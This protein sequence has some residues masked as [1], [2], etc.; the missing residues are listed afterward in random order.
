[1]RYSFGDYVL[2]TQRQELQRVGEPIKL[3]RKVFQVLAYLL[4]H[5]ERVVPK[6]ELLEHLW[7]DQF[8]GDETLKSCIKTLRK[9][10]GDSRRTARFLHTVHGQGYRFVAAVAVQESL[11]VDEAPPAL[12]LRGSEGATCQAEVPSPALTPSHADL[13]STPW[14]TLEG[15]YKQAT[16]L[17]GA[18]A[19]APTLAAR[20]GP[21]A[22]YHL[23]REVLALAQATVQRYE[24]TLHQVSGE[25]FLALF[26]VPV[27]QEDHARRAV[28]AAL[29]L[30]QRLY[31]PE[32]LRGLLHGVAI[33]LG[34]HSGPVVV[35]SLTYEPQRLYIAAGETLH[36]ATRLQE[37]ATPDSILVSAAT[38]VLVQD[39][40]Q[41]EACETL[42]LDGPSTPVPVYAIHG[43]RRRRAGVPRR[44]PRPLSRFVGRTQELALLQARLEQALGGQGQVLGI[45]GEPG[46]GK[47][48]LLA[49]FAHRLE[50]QA[51]TYCE[52][53]CLPYSSS[54]PYLPVCD[55]LR[56]LW[57]LPDIASTPAITATVS[58]RLREAGVVSEAEALMLLQLLDVSV[59]LAP[60]ATLDP[61]Q[62]KAQTFALLWHIIQ[63]TSQRQPLLLAVENLHWI[64]PTSEEWL[65]SLVERL[66]DMAVLF[67]AT[68]RPGYQ[69]PWLRHSAVTQMA[70]SRLSPHDS[71]VVLQSVPQ[72]AQLPGPLQQ[73]IVVKAAGNPFFVEELAWAAV[74][75]GGQAG[76]VPLPDTI[77]AVLAARLDRQPP[78]A[79][80]LVQVAAVIGP[81]VPEPLLTA[82][83]ELPEA[84]LYAGL[85]HLQ[86]TEFLY[87]IRF[88]PERVYTFKH[89][90]THE[91]A[92]GSL[93]QERRRA[94][95]AQIV[96]VLEMLAGKRQ[97]EQVERLAQHAMGGEIWD[98]ALRYCWQAGLKARTGSAYREAVVYFEQ[99]LAALA[100]LPPD[101]ATMEQAIELYFDLGTA[102]LPLEQWEQKLIY[103][104]AAEQMAKGLADQRRLGDV[105]HRMAT[106]LRSMWN[107]EPA[108]TYCQHAHAIATALVDIKLQ[109]WVNFDMG[110]IMVDLGDYRQAMACFRQTLKA[111]EGIPYD[112][113]DRAS[114]HPAI[115]ARVYIV[116]CLSQLGEFAK[117]LAYGDDACQMAEARSRPYE[118]V[119]VYTRVGA[120]YVY[121]GALHK[122]IPLLERA[123]ALSQDT[124]ILALYSIAAPYL[125]R[126]YA[127][128]GRTVDVHPLLEEVSKKLL[129]PNSALACGE[130]YL[131]VGAVEAGLRLAQRVLADA[132][133]HKMQPWE[134]WALWLLGDIAMH[135]APPGVAPA[136]AYYQQALALAETMGMRPL[137]AH[138]H[139]GLG[140]LYA[141]ISQLE[142]ARAA[143]TTSIELYRAMEMTF[144][145][146]QAEATLA[147]VG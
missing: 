59:D 125:A 139:R 56:Q 64:D 57:G 4:A 21:E 98:K 32:A 43:L 16:A 130:A 26:G 47:S 23:M 137:Q 136:E 145:L 40:V 115:Q 53:H 133:E 95:H 92:Y 19:E 109:M 62:R 9:A 44:G 116:R 11:A 87:Q 36:L 41:G 78:G 99:A 48:R 105:Y 12:L 30:R 6:Q 27:A 42:A 120:L 61:Q 107:L 127:L 114:A 3:R 82:I 74:E 84:A 31:T 52:G 10:L 110:Q 37:R 72:A 15:E 94:L 122:A 147:Q 106:T 121:Q 140:T 132:R 14:E 73:A 2:D 131:R 34:L 33:R 79:K 39:E 129:S 49:E 46:M 28:L 90:L 25:G 1:M 91:V 81:E 63:H 60:L 85:V 119:A 58:Q 54:A 128:A 7:P 35:G 86:E 142:Q 104:R 76:T 89:A 22:M 50:G 67:L 65:T 17:C 117:G 38:Y 118:C 8:V 146:P 69:P 124:N 126:A 103:L 83:A 18:L 88:F 112:P 80:R 108:L 113:F 55:L 77:E 144:W 123:V 101:R 68:Y 13:E 96:E 24:G 71:L 45:T 70:L 141:R 138:C 75:H 143:L 134:A 102:L 93:L 20:L 135:G 51:V 97:D 29:D 5:C 100:H 111:L 66:G